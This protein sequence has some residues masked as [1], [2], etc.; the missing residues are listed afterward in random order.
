[1]RK[2]AT[3]LVAVVAFPFIIYA[4]QITVPSAP[5]P[6]YV[7]LSTTTGAYYPAATSTLGISGGSATPGGASSNI[8]FNQTGAFSGNSGFVYNGTNVGIGS[9]TPSSLLS[10]GGILSL[11]A[12]ATTSSILGSLAWDGTAL[13]AKGGVASTSVTGWYNVGTGNEL[14]VFLVGGQSNAKGSD[15]SSAGSPTTTPG[16]CYQY[17]KGI[18]SPGNDPVYPSMTGSAWP[19]FCVTYNSLTGHKVLIVSAALGATSQT[20]AAD[21]GNGNWDTSGTLVAAAIADAQGAMKAAALSGFTPVFKGVLWSQGEN[22]AVA[23][24]SALI[25]QSTYVTAFENMINRYQLAFGSSTPLYIFRTGTQVGA[26]D[27]GYAQIRSAQS[28]VANASPYTQVVWYGAIDFPALGL[29]DTTQ[30]TIIHYLQAG[31]NLMGMIGAQ[32]IVAG[33]ANQT[34][35]LQTQ[36]FF[37]P[38]PQSLSVGGYS[39]STA[40]E[41]VSSSTQTD[42]TQPGTTTSSVLNQDTTTGNFS[43]FTWRGVNMLLNEFIAS[44]ISSVTTSHATGQESADLSFATRFGGSLIERLRLLAN[45]NLQIGALISGIPQDVHILGITPTTSNTTGSNF[46]FDAPNGT[47]T[48]ASGDF[49]FRV[50]SS[51]STGIPAITALSTSTLTI[52][53]GTSASFN[54]TVPSA[55]NDILIVG[56][57]Y[58]TQ[59][60]QGTTVFCGATPLINKST[61][62]GGSR[63]VEMW[64]LVDP[65]VGTC[66]ISINLTSTLNIVAGA[67]TFA[68]VNPATPFGSVVSTS[69]TGAGTGT[70]NIPTSS[71]QMVVDVLSKQNNSAFTAGGSQTVGYVSIGGQSIASSNQTSSGTSVNDSWTWPTSGGWVYTA[72]PLQQIANNTPD[73]LSEMLRVDGNGIGIGSSSPGSLLSIN[74]VANLTIGTSTFY[75]SGGINFVGLAGCPIA[76]NGTCLSTGTS[77]TLPVSVPNG[78]TASTTLSGILVGNGTSAL[79]SLTIGAGLSLSGTTLSATAGA[80]YFT[81]SGTATY[82]STGT[83]LGIGTTSPFSELAIHAPNGSTLTSLFSIGS[84]TAIAT[85]TFLNILN[86]GNVGIGTTTPGNL[87]SIQGASTANQVVIAYDNADSLGIQIASNGAVFFNGTQASVTY[88]FTT[89]G[90]LR[91]F[92]SG[93]AFDAGNAAGPQFLSAAC[94]V[95][96]VLIPDRAQAT[97]GFGC[98][99]A[100]QITTLVGGAEISRWTATG[101]GI[102]TTT[103][104][105]PLTVVAASSTVATGPYKGLV[106]I[107]AGLEN[108]TVVLFQEIDQW[109]HVITSGDAPSVS[110]GTS[111]VSGND[112]NGTVT[113]TG[114]LLT[115]ITLTFAH[116]WVT[117]PDCTMSDNS[118]G[119]TAD[120]TSISA[121]Q[122]VFGF[123]A[124][125]NS[126]IVWYGCRGHQ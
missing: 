69:G 31:Y 122:V 92:F 117:S 33:N 104:Q 88:N 75:S 63:A 87:L 81:N 41:V 112:N 86:T 106:S 125:I 95:N 50:A 116:A 97:T 18:I 42:V 65:P 48:G 4:A 89:S 80:G 77:I 25:T 67:Q 12:T 19:Q 7:L 62:Y 57:A 91:A 54:Y 37:V 34:I 16:T 60:P 96:A 1:M 85:T 28:I 36:T 22:D 46:Y 98:G 111:T 102:G 58:N 121:T 17:S 108:T 26:N 93:N 30:G 11:G 9:S 66:T 100:G 61:V 72:A 40:L 82:L 103:P 118:T 113:V 13:Y 126:G 79:N 49:I 8:Q 83:M 5:G 68:N 27:Y 70:I 38:G 115:S 120:I 107:I 90:T 109:G 105:A 21:T 78:G 119:I 55:S 114:T 45:G 64:Y 51:S 20:V 15:S 23:I 39:S 24:N 124:G 32:N 43:S 76:V 94:T 10:I 74:G 110:G 59:T 35:P 14:D 6:N 99:T 84:S 44:A 71:G 3:I 52:T 101:F 73:S 29:M 2:I 56:V 53:T 47:G 123:S